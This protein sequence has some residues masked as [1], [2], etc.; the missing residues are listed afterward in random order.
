MGQSYGTLLG[1]TYASLFPTHIRAMVLDSVIDPALSFDQITLGQAEGSSRPQ[2][3]LRLVRRR[4]RLPVAP[5]PG[6]H[7][8]AAA[9]LNTAATS[10]A[11]AGAGSVAGVGQLYDAVLD[12]LYSQSQWPQLGAALAAD[13]AD[14]GAPGSRSRTTTT[15]AAPP[16]PTTPPPPSTASTTPCRATSPRT[17]PWPRRSRGRP[18]LRPPAGVG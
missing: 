8:R 2:R 6:P 4:R 14:N 18:G 11:P 5:R 13:A 7:R 12:S 3:V 16:T 1:L 9:L 10:P 15:R 17:A